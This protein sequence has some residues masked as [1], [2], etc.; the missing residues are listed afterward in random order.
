LAPILDEGSAARNSR[1]VRLLALHLPQF[2]PIPEN[3]E[4]WG[5]GF[6]EW[7]NVARAR[8]WFPGH[9]QPQLPADLG[10][11]D[12][13]AKEA[14]AAQAELAREYGIYGFVHYHYWFNGRMLLERPVNEILRT[15]E[16]DF[17]FCLCWANEPWTRSWTSDGSSVLVEQTYSP[18]D[19]ARHIEW[20]LPVFSDHRYV[21]IDGKPVFFV[22]RVS[23]LPDARRT[24]DLWRE[25]A[26]RFGLPGLYIV[27]FE[28]RN[29]KGTPESF[30]A[31]AAAEFQPDMRCLGRELPPYLPMRELRRLG[32]LPF[33]MRSL[34]LHS[35]SDLVRRALERNLPEYKF[36]RCVTP[37]WDNTPRRIGSAD[38]AW[39]TLGNTPEKYGRW[40]SEVRRS[41][42]PWSPEENLVLVNAW[43]EWAEGNH[44]EPCQRWGR[45]FLEATRDA[46]DG[47]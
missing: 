39:I 14:R 34:V 33:P 3:D 37:G 6:T 1:N 15:G 47:A 17:P 13:R 45:K 42:T 31:D 16:P 40:L 32:V 7:R 46:L 20:L 44:L 19:D 18:E 26:V 38:A 10:F 28:T 27:R 8:P 23:R 25:R 36:Y 2:H 35:Y 24:F 43:N 22:Y 5:K 4:W 9:H 30:G 21:R 11:Y 12:L 41:F 29:E